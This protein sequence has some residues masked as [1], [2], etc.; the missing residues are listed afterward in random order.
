M[1]IL[2]KTLKDLM[3]MKLIILL[4]NYLTIMFRFLVFKFQNFY[5]YFIISV[6]EF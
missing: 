2:V 3:L 4:V 5:L 6:T 1:K